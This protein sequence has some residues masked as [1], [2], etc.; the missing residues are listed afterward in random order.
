MAEDV[1]LARRS[2]KT[3]SHHPEFAA[4]TVC[5]T[6]GAVTESSI[7]LVIFDLGGVL[8]D[9]G[10]VASMRELARI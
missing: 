3:W 10:G 6:I 7:D 5:P 9:P 1:A 4:T 8:I 2:S